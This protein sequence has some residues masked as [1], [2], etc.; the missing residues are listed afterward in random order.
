MHYKYRKTKNYRADVTFGVC[1][2]GICVVVIVV[3]GPT[4]REHAIRCLVAI[5]IIWA[6]DTVCSSRP[7]GTRNAGI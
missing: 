5:S 2:R 1:A 4:V 3:D 7:L 6:S